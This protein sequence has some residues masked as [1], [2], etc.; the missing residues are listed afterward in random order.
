[1]AQTNHDQPSGEES[2][3]SFDHYF[4]WTSL[5]SDTSEGYFTTVKKHRTQ[6]EGISDPEREKA[7]HFLL[8]DNDLILACDLG[9]ND[10]IEKLI[11]EGVDVNLRDPIGRTALHFAVQ[12]GNIRAIKMLLEAGASTTVMDNVGLTPLQICVMRRPSV[13]VAKLLF[14]YGAVI[15]PRVKPLSTG[16]F[17]QFTM[18]C[19]PTPEE[20]E[21]L[22]LLLEKGALINDPNVPGGRSV[23]HFAAMSN[24]CKL[25]HVLIDLG[26]DVFAKNHRGETPYDVAV[27]FKCKEA[28]NCLKEHMNLSPSKS[29]L[30]SRSGQNNPFDWSSL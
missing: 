12:D 17:L 1:M 13:E 6:I 4:S 30:S 20:T 29:S 5:H 24:N 28:T 21:L 3:Y 19:I 8:S 15:L 18:M 9:D 2:D 14:S 7:V 23:L 10:L 26:A 22:A 16:L 11:S 27:T 25:I